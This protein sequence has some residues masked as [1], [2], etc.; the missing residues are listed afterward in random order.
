MESPCREAW[1]LSGQRILGGVLGGGHDGCADRCDVSAGLRRERCV[2]VRETP[3]RAAADGYGA[4][5]VQLLLVGRLSEAINEQ[6]WNAA[7]ASSQNSR[8]PSL[9]PGSAST[10]ESQGS[11]SRVS[12]SVEAGSATAGSPSPVSS[13]RCPAGPIK[14]EIDN[15][16]GPAAE[17]AESVVWRESNCTPTARNGS[18]GSAGLFQLLHHDDLLRAACPTLD[19]STS[20][21][22]PDCNIRAA[23]DLYDAAGI[24][25]WRL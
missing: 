3:R 17:W 10:G 11:G 5:R 4:L 20:W 14:D 15:V 8:L 21:A 22:V 24:A 19:P 16:F 12:R 2:L 25:P 1:D 9:Q 18:S 23:K 7:V 6:R 13:A